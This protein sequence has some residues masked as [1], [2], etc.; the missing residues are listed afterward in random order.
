MDMNEYLNPNSITK[1]ND[2]IKDLIKQMNSLSLAN[3]ADEFS[4]LN[5][6]TRVNNDKNKELGIMA[7]VEHLLRYL[8]NPSFHQ[9]HTTTP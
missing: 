9:V 3:D 2:H 1:Y 8:E 6:Y 4:I 7:L 5:A